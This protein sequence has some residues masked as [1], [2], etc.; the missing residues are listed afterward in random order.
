M[1]PVDVD[2]RSHALVVGGT[3]MLRGVSLYLAEQGYTVSVV[4]RRRDRLQALVDSA[5]AFRGEI[6]PLQLDYGDPVELE[7]ALA[8]SAGAFGPIALAVCW[9][10]SVATD[11]L[12]VVARTIAGAGASPRL[13]H[14][15]GSASAKP[16]AGGP[17]I[18]QSLLAFPT[19]RYRQVILGF[20]I[21]NGRSRWLSHREISDGVISAV[22]SDREITIVGTVEPWSMRP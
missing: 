10:H 6:V 20:V 4:A 15:R 5:A 2:D 14:I 13:F 1:T 19:L 9:V 7:R 21:E 16:A 12:S 3:G 11:P 17:R 8:R 18:P 22:S